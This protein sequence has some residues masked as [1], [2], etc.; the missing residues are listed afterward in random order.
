[1]RFAT[2]RCAAAF[3]RFVVDNPCANAN[4]AP[5]AVIPWT[6]HAAS[7]ANVSQVAKASTSASAIDDANERN[8]TPRTCVRA[9][10]MIV[11]CSSKRSTYSCSCVMRLSA[12]RD[13]ASTTSRTSASR[14]FTNSSAGNAG[15]TAL[16]TGK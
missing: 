7:S 15:G 12:R 1:M 9:W 4:K 10:R 11:A 14:A 3:K 2:S 5:S 16:S 6:H 8:N 13:F